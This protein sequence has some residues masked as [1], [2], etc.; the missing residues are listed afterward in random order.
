M[1]KRTRFSFERLPHSRARGMAAEREA[2]RFLERAGLEI[3]ERNVRTGAGE[4][5]LVAREG[6]TYCFVEIKARSR[7][8]Y[9]GA[10]SSVPRAKQRRLTRAASLYLAREKLSVPCRFDVVTLDREESGGWRICHF[11]NAFE[12]CWP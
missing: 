11:R 4:I 3:V 1:R 12:A 2:E 10:V 5:D 8:D 9:G 7:A 6:E